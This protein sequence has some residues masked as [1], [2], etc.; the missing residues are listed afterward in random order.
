MYSMGGLPV[1]YVYKL[2][3]LSN[4]SI[5]NFPTFTF[6]KGLDPNYQ[7]TGCAIKYLEK[8]EEIS[9]FALI[10]SLTTPVTSQFDQ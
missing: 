1:V 4:V 7:G 8:R 5:K 9:T 2:P 10:K 3:P 6:R